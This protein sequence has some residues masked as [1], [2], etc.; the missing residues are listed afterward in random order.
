MK[1]QGLAA[2]GAVSPQTA[3]K[4]GSLLGVKYI[5]VG[6]IDRFAINNTKAGSGGIGGNL[7]Q[8]ATVNLRFIDTTTGER[9]ESLTDESLCDIA[10]DIWT[11]A[12]I[13]R[14]GTSAERYLVDTARGW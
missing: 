1:E 3:A 11:I 13:E 2:S 6:G 8:A 5:V 10:S 12:R 9:A 14:S 7:Q 4:V